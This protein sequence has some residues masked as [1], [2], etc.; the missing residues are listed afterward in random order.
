MGRRSQPIHPLYSDAQPRKHVFLDTEATVRPGHGGL[1]QRWALAVTTFVKVDR[2]DRWQIGATTDWTDPAAMWAKIHAYALGGG[3]TIVWAH[4]LPYDLRISRALEH[5]PLLGYTL[6]GIVLERTAAWASFQYINPDTDEAS[7]LMCCDLASWINQPL[8]V[9]AGDLEMKQLPHDFATGDPAGL[10]A[11]CRQ[12]VAITL[13]AVRELLTFTRTHELGPFR[14]TGAGQAY[15]AWRRRFISCPVYVHDDTIALA[16]ERRAMWTGRCEAWRHGTID[17]PGIA[18]WDLRLAYCHIAAECPVPVALIRETGP[19]TW[20]EYTRLVRSG[21][22]LADVRITTTTPIVPTA[23]DDTI[24]WPTG[25]FT[26]ILWNPE[27]TQAAAQG[28]HIE[29]RRAWIY[30]TGPALADFATWIL[31][32]LGPAVDR[33]QLVTPLQARLLK[34]WSRA[35]VGRMALRYQRW[36]RFGWADDLD[37]RLGQIIDHDTGT[38]TDELRVGH[39]VMTLA[40][41]CEADQSTPMVTGWVMSEA[42]RRLWALMRTAGLPDVI[43]VDTDS[44]I[45]TAQGDARLH[46]AQL[47]GDAYSLVR[48]TSIRRLVVTGP[49]NL[50]VE[51]VRRLAGVPTRAHRTGPLTYEGEVWTSVKTSMRSGT[52]DHV[53]VSPRTYTLDPHDPRRTHHPDGTTSPHHT[54]EDPPP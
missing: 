10:L 11:R 49:R 12:D 2:K 26:T 36:E 23:D 52:M 19:L 37:L 50:E 7:T 13:A 40:E 44:I 39:D 20:L 30:R 54:G 34:H 1:E 33:D 18:E 9:I 32:G 15:A 29:I 25:T 3:R 27:L 14:P 41:M 43:Y 47:A 42:R 4:N 28:A 22:V 24:H 45:T 5:L 8:A 17:E 6:Q 38:V 35:A 51:S 16:H 53:L 31:N 48:K 46:R 21:A